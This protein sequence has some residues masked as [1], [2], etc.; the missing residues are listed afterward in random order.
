MVIFLT[1]NHFIDKITHFF[2]KVKK[3]E[4]NKNLLFKSIKLKKNKKESEM[5]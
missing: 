1:N 3:N 2:I 4:F 5:E